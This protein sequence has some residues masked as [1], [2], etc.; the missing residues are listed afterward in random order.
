MKHEIKNWCSKQE[1]RRCK[2]GSQRE[3]SMHS[4]NSCVRK[5]MLCNTP[6]HHIH[7]SDMY[8]TTCHARAQMDDL[9]HI[10]SSR[11]LNMDETRGE[12][13]LQHSQGATP[14]LPSPE[15]RTSKSPS[16]GSTLTP[17]IDTPAMSSSLPTR[18]NRRN[19]SRNRSPSLVRTGPRLSDFQSCP[20]PQPAPR[21]PRKARNRSAS[22][23]ARR[24]RTRFVLETRTHKRGY[25][26]SRPRC[27]D[28][29]PDSP[30]VRK[31]TAT[32][33]RRAKSPSP[34]RTRCRGTGEQ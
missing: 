3:F 24:G 29:C 8:K 23:S 4:A 1:E 20:L 32:A 5:L 10:F 26:P 16:P 25:A 34:A 30:V 12:N 22:V 18:R 11:A 14:L 27:E 15:R 7:A 19:R 31:F 2:G 13:P 6:L 21:R 33:A 28:F 9:A 17:T